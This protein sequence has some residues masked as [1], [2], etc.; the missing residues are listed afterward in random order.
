MEQLIEIETLKHII[1]IKAIT[2]TEQQQNK[3]N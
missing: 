3:L 2:F 1:E